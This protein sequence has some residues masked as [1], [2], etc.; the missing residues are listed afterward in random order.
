MGKAKKRNFKTCINQGGAMG[1]LPSVYTRKEAVK[2]VMS[3]IK[4]NDH[5]S[6]TKD[7]ISLF[8]IKAEELSEAGA[9]YEDLVA[10]RLVLR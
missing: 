10:L 4:A 1:S 5:G 2:F 3:R 6:A 7:M 9:S 8:G